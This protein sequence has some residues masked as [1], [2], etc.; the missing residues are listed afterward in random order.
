MPGEVDVLLSPQ[1]CEKILTK[2]DEKAKLTKYEINRIGG[3]VF[4]FLSSHYYVTMEYSKCD[5]KGIYS[6]RFFLKTMPRSNETQRAYI[7]SMGIFKKEILNYK[8]LLSEFSLLTGRPFA[9]KYYFSK[10]DD[11]LVMEDLSSLNYRV[12]ISLFNY[13]EINV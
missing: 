6:Q 8:N 9:A 5:G 7:E 1:D 4:G 11:C 12:S 3:K 10:D 13:D 2:C